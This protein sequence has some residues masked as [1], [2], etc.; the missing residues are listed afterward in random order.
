MGKSKMDDLHT[1]CNMLERSESNKYLKGIPGMKE[2]VAVCRMLR[3]FYNTCYRDGN[4]HIKNVV[5]DIKSGKI[6]KLSQIEDCVVN[7]IKIQY[8][9]FDFAKLFG[10]C[11]SFTK[12]AKKQIP[13]AQKDVDSKFTLKKN[14]PKYKAIL[15][16]YEE[17]DAFC[18]D[19][20]AYILGDKYQNP[21][22]YFEDKLKA[23]SAE[24]IAKFLK[25][26]LING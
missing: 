7:G 8:A 4:W 3:E 15:T 22:K 1:R 19:C 13:S 6:S 24:E 10:L 25:V 2:L 16:F 17:G 14:L 12:I 23:K 26:E 20:I 21:K 18:E 11:D 5:E 9:G